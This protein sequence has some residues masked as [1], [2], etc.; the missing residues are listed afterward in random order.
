[1]VNSHKRSI[2]KLDHSRLILIN[3]HS[4]Y[5]ELKNPE[6]RLANKCL[7]CANT[8]PHEHDIIGKIKF[9]PKDKGYLLSMVEK[10]KIKSK[11]KGLEITSVKTT[12]IGDENVDYAKTD[13]N[14]KVT[15]LTLQEVGN[16]AEGAQYLAQQLIK[17]GGHVTYVSIKYGDKRHVLSSAPKS[18]LKN[19]AIDKGHCDK[20]SSNQFET[21]AEMQLHFMN[22]HR[23]NLQL[24][25]ITL[26]DGSQDGDTVEDRPTAAL[27]QCDHCP[28]EWDSD[29]KKIQHM[30]EVHDQRQ[31]P[32]CLQHFKT[33]LT[34][35]KHSCS[36]L[37][38]SSKA[39][40]KHPCHL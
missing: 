8:K 4:S 17:Q 5:L 37:Q 1:M 7:W 25:D 11:T 13:E 9:D 2:F 40:R 24:K 3:S 30:N 29:E 15:H 12:S 38:D 33:N 18:V 32:K 16:E 35:R 28:L 22:V 26:V 27:F 20:C 39:N 14:V 19:S 21:L 6:D 10:V 23:Y 36:S 34:F 31:C